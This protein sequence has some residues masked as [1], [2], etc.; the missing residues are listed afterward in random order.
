MFPCDSSLSLYLLPWVAI[1]IK[2]WCICSRKDSRSMRISSVFVPGSFPTQPFGFS[3]SNRYN[4]PLLLSTNTNTDCVELR[5]CSCPAPWEE[6]HAT[7]SE[8]RERE[9]AGC[10]LTA[11]FLTLL[12]LFY[13]NMCKSPEF[14][15]FVYSCFC[16]LFLGYS[17]NHPSVLR[18]Y[19]SGITPG[20]FREPY[21]LQKTNLN[22]LCVRLGHACYFSGPIY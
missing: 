19:S 21:V 10:E 8:N 1:G 17:H 14:H 9:G 18:D 7:L 5:R 3:W 11:P 22:W 16:F 2:Q 4:V 6:E 13:L 20:D 12:F 15:S